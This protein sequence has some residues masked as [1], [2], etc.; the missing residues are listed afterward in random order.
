MHPAEAHPVTPRRLALVLALGLCAVLL[1]ALLCPL[2]GPSHVSLSR[3]FA[4]EW[5]D[6]RVFFG[7]RLPRLLLSLL[8]GGALSI[9][10][11]T[12]AL[13]QLLRKF[14]F[15]Y[16]GEVPARMDATVTLTPKGGRLPF[17]VHARA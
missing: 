10:E 6:S 7:V 13:T 8:C 1:C 12:L 17:R 15:E 2:V 14:R 9:A 4:G 11:I 3:A 5:P 16:L